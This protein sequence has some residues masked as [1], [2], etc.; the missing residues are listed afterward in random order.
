M[1]T[2]MTVVGDGPLGRRARLGARRG[3]L[4]LAIVVATIERVSVAGSW[5]RQTSRGFDPLWLATP[6]SSGRWQHGATVAA[7]YLADDEQTAWAE[8]Y[9]ALA[10]IAIPPAHGTPR[11]LWRWTIAVGRSPTSRLRRSSPA[12]SYRSPGQ[13]DE[14]GRASRPPASSYT[15]TATAG[16]S[17]R[18]PHAQTTRPYACSVKA[19]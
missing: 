2:V 16:F 10:E 17:T 9:R 15:V 6:P 12:L 8:W 14:R 5:W 3:T 1:L 11:D 13:A 18:A 19:R 4:Q 7:I